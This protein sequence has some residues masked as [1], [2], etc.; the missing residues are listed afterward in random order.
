MSD[1]RLVAARSVD[2]RCVRIALVMLSLLLVMAPAC[3]VRAVPALPGRAQTAHAG[4][5]AVSE[6]SEAK[7]EYL[8]AVRVWGARLTTALVVVGLVALVLSLVG[9]GAR[10]GL[11]PSE[12]VAV[13][14]LSAVVPM[15]QYVLAA[16]GVMAAN[17]AI[18]VAAA[19]CVASVGVLVWSRLKRRWRSA[20]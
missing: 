9:P 2:T 10:L 18:L 17:T 7:V 3:A 5:S 12:A 13:L 4:A 20:S 15:V 19:G 8:R 6:A 14:G 16:W 1:G 11:Y